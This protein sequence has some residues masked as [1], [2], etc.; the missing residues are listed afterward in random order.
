MTS[1][2]YHVSTLPIKENQP[3]EARD[4]PHSSRRCSW[5]GG[6]SA[7]S[8]TYQGGGGSGYVDHVELRINQSYVQFM[9][10]VG[11]AGE[12]S[13][14]T[15]IISGNTTYISA[16]SGS[17]GSSGSSSANGGRG[18]SGGGGGPADGG[19]DG[20][21]GEDGSYGD[22]GTGSGADLSRVPIMSNSLRYF[23]KRF[24]ISFCGINK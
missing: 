1:I 10:D 22:G 21:D 5:R 4:M 3:S 7:A 19:S 23:F 13:V 20:G 11:S 2:F 24:K 9:A 12:E 18:F 6:G 8:G 17:Q 14:V 16:D 15:D